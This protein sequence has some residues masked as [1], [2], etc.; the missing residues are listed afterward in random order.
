[1]PERNM[2]EPIDQNSYDEADLTVD[3]AIAGSTGDTRRDSAQS[4]DTES[5]DNDADQWK[6]K[7]HELQD[8]LLRSQAELDNFR[9]RTRREMDD[10]RRFA[11]QSLLTDLLPVLDNISRAI[12][13]ADKTDDRASLLSGFKLLASQLDGVFERHN[14][15]RI[16]AQGQAFDPALHQA[17]MQQPSAEHPPNTVVA[18]GQVG[19]TLHDR[20]IRPAQVVVSKAE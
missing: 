5:S 8:R 1:M 2:P 19:Y 14:A 10:E 20:V 11:E 15:K 6:L 12:E 7:F 13:A 17:I 9:K 16:D 3:E 4:F 18:V